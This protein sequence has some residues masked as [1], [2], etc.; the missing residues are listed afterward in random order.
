MGGCHVLDNAIVS[1]L[2]CFGSWRAIST[3][4]FVAQEVGKYYNSGVEPKIDTHSKQKADEG[5]S[6]SLNKSR[7]L[8]KHKKQNKPLSPLRSPLRSPKVNGSL[9]RLLSPK[10]TETAEGVYTAECEA[11]KKSSKST[12]AIRQFKQTCDCRVPFLQKK[13]CQDCMWDAGNCTINRKNSSHP[14]PQR[15]DDENTKMFVNC[16]GCWWEQPHPVACTNPMLRW[17]WGYVYHY[18]TGGCRDIY[19]DETEMSDFLDSMMNSADFGLNSWECTWNHD[20]KWWITAFLWCFCPCCGCAILTVCLKGCLN[21][22]TCNLF[23]FLHMTVP[24]T[25]RETYTVFSGAEAV[26]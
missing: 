22:M 16:Y 18:F 23:S 14:C 20:F 5:M 2:T 1:A 13:C 24:K 9:H 11:G 10:V 3:P 21:C 8:H 26:E 7:R 19:A 25:D 17:W 6:L 15:G 4:V 12:P